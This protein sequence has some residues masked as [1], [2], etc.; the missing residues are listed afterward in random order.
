MQSPTHRVVPAL[1]LSTL[2]A[3]GAFA[4]S[5]P[6]P[7]I[8][9]AGAIEYLSGG[10]GK[11]EASA[12]EHASKQWPLTLEFW[13]TRRPYR[14]CLACTR[15]SN[16]LHEAAR[17]FD[18]EHRLRNI[19]RSSAY[20]AFLRQEGLMEVVAR[21]WRVA[22]AERR[23][24]GRRRLLREDELRAVKREYARRKRAAA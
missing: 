23:L 21:Q 18:P 14:M 16:R 1:L 5:A 10:I 22:Q 15:E 7:P 6:L 20:R 13:P 12:V 24:Q 4:Q 8:Q 9:H 17:R 2:L 19:A 3:G 11:D